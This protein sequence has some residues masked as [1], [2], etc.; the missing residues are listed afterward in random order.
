MWF[1]DGK[2][3]GNNTNDQIL[4]AKDESK[5]NEEIESCLT[6]KNKKLRYGILKQVIKHLLFIKMQY[7]RTC[8]NEFHIK[9]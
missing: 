6:Y 7:T 8:M 4:V 1:E 9:F 3:D 5:K 2:D